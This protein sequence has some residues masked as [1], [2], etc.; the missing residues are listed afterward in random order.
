MYVQVDK[1]LLLHVLLKTINIINFLI[2]NQ[3][4]E[5]ELH[6]GLFVLEVC[7][8][9]NVSIERIEITV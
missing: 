4:N 2:Q 6:C 1:L 8:I 5:N 9:N 3:S 7:T